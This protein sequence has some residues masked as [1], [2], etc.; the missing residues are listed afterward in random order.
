VKKN[1]KMRGQAF[2]TFKNVE[3]AGK[4]KEATHKKFSLFEKTIVTNLFHN[5]KV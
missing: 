5:Q 3:D 2:V 4:A 1:I